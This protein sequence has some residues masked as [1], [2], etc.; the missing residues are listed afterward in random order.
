LGRDTIAPEFKNALVGR[1]L[2]SVAFSVYQLALGFGMDA[3]I[4]NA[5][6]G[7]NATV[8]LL[9]GPETIEQNSPMFKDA[10][11]KLLGDSVVN[12]EHRNGK[13]FLI[14]FSSGAK[15]SIDL[16]SYDGVEAAIFGNT[17]GLIVVFN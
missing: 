4:D 9:K 6:F 3:P 17:D 5:S 10:I 1:K 2:T 13:D 16:V 15:V 11:C 7:I 14:S 12:L 8:V